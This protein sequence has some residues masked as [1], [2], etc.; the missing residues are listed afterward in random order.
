VTGSARFARLIREAN[1]GEALEVARQQVENGAQIIDINM[2]EG[3]LDSKA[4]M[5][6][7]PQSDR[8]RTGHQP[9]ADHDRLVEMGGDRSRPQ[10]RAGQAIV[11]SISLKEG[12]ASFLHQA[13]SGSSLWRGRGGDGLR[14]G[15]DRPTPWR[16]SRRSCSA[17]YR[18]L[19]DEV[20]FPPEDI[21]FDPNIFAVATGIEEHNNYAVDFIEACAYVKTQSAPC[22]HLRRRLQCVVFVPRQQPGARG[23]PCG[24]PLSRDP[25]PG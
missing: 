12:E 7:I 6:T 14:R 16:A 17:A 3:M 8:R 15:R 21:I 1:Y 13:G 19:V 5:V 10:V 22:A 11:N 24:V 4:A 23:D 2:D 20:G 25:A 18:L 9:G